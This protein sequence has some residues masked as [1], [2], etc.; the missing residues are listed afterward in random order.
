MATGNTTRDQRELALKIAALDPVLAY[1][2]FLIA[3]AVPGAEAE[4]ERRKLP[5]VAGVPG[6]LFGAGVWSAL[7]ALGYLLAR[8]EDRISR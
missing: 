6:N 8:G 5:R 3:E 4:D 2:P 7:S 1:A